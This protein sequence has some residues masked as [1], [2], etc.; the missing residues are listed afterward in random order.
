MALASGDVELQHHHGTMVWT[1]VGMDQLRRE[2]CLCLRCC[3]LHRCPTAKSLMDI[4]VGADVALAVTR[5]KN[6]TE[7]KG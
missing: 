2:R 6:W 4:C 1:E 7:R 5:C 3:I